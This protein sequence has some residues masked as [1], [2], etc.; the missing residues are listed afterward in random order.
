MLPESLLVKALYDY[1]A[2]DPKV[3]SCSSDERFIIIKQSKPDIDWLYVVN[4]QGRLGY[5]PANY[6]VQERLDDVSFLRLIDTIISVLDVHHNNS[7]IISVRQINHA[8]VKLTQLRCEAVNSLYSTSTPS[9][10]VALSRPTGYINNFPTN[11]SNLSTLSSSSECPTKSHNL[12]KS[13]QDM[14]T[15]TDEDKKIVESIKA[16]KDM[17]TQSNIDT[18]LT[19]NKM[20]SCNASTQLNY[21]NELND[22]KSTENE[23][24]QTSSE[25]DK[26]ELVKENQFCNHISTQSD[27]QENQVS[28]G[29]NLNI[30][31]NFISELVERIRVST[32]LSHEMC[33]FSIQIVI[34]YLKEKITNM[35]SNFDLILTQLDQVDKNLSPSIVKSS[36]DYIQ[37]KKLFEQLWNCKNDEQQQSWPLHEDEAIINKCF[38]RLTKILINAN[39]IVTRE[40]IAENNYDNIQM[41][42]TYFQ[43][44]NRSSIKKNMYATI[45]AIIKLDLNL[46]E[47]LFLSSVFP[48]ALANEMINYQNDYDR[49]SNA[50]LLF[51]LIFSSGQAP[52]VNIYEHV[53]HNFFS[54]LFQ[55]IEGEDSELSKPHEHKLPAEKIIPPILAFNL[56]FSSASSNLVL[57]ALRSRPNFTKLMENLVSYLNWDEDPTL[58]KMFGKL[59]IANSVRLNAVHKLLIEITGDNELAQRCYLNDVSVM[60]DIIINHLNN[61][62]PGDLNRLTYLHLASNVIANTDYLNE[63]AKS[64]ELLKCLDDIQNHEASS[65]SEKRVAKEIKAKI[66]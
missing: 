25:A 32:E 9:P 7:D 20:S 56:H 38:A 8:Q 41:L 12:P 44:E 11:L 16:T 3:L 31:E 66:N 5:I 48:A 27:V 39:P 1:K 34:N 42:I 33:K 36:S 54:K 64:S 19:T 6:T 53:N 18:T 30:D 21:Q 15:H 50:A 61:L 47:D 43:M 14:S 17:S 59:K 45:I 52:P 23:F 13:H 55:M 28:E 26:M 49:W 51:T 2:S 40:A 35:A 22:P 4:C 37:L 24:T 63:H 10:D 62:S 65:E 58:L 46:I 60:I 29:L 57:E